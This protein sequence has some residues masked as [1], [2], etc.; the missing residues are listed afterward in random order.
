M[1]LAYLALVARIFLLGYEKILVKKMGAGSENS[2][3][4]FLYFLSSTAF[5]LPLIFFIRPAENYSL[6]VYVA[7]SSF[8]YCIAFLFYVKSISIGEVSLVSPLYNFNVIFLLVTA[9]VFLGEKITIMK[10]SGVLVLLYG[11]SLLNRQ[12]SL[13][14]SISAMAKDRACRLM[15]ICS[16]FMAIGRTIDG[17]FIKSFD[18]LLY[19]ILIYSFM[20]AFLLVYVLYD[21]QL[22]A[23]R[24]LYYSRKA[25]TLTAGAVNAY[26]YL[27]LLYAITKI[28]V[29]VAEPASMLS[30]VVT[31][32]LSHFMLGENIKGRLAGVLVIIA[33]SWALFV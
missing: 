32:I 31:V 24:D 16:F 27:F 15:L 21:G 10:V 4:T 6:V 5:I 20:S 26:T 8:I 19:A 17:F 33:G 14:L 22:K 12:K 25:V 1:L 13:W 30:M 29:S 2:A 23:A 7:I 9:A 28:D 11:A 3:A 18:P